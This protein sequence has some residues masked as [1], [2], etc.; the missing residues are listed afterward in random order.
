M[1]SNKSAHVW[2]GRFCLQLMRLRPDIG[3]PAAVR[4]AVQAYPY[5]DSLSPED[6][7]NLFTRNRTPGEAGAEPRSARGAAAAGRIPF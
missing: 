6:A 7:A 3:M 2:L 5:A 1:P 4:R